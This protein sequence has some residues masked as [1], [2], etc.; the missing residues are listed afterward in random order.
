MNKQFGDKASPSAGP[1][2]QTHAKQQAAVRKRIWLVQVSLFFSLW[3]CYGLLINSRNLEA[4]NLQQAG[5]EAMV[6][7]GQF[8][9]D[10]SSAPQLQMRAYYDKGKPFGDVFLYN[11]KQ[12][13]NKQPGQF[14][15]GA[16]V[17]LF[18]H[19][20]GLNYVNN[21]LLTSA[22]VTFFTASLFAAVT[23]AAVFGIV[24]EFT[25]RDSL[26][27]PMA[28]ALIYGL[29]TTALV[30][31]GVALHDPLASGFLIIAFYIVLLLGRLQMPKRPAKTAAAAAGVCLGLTVTT[32]LLPL[33]MSFVVGVYLVSLRRR[34]LIL[35]ALIGSLVGLAPLL[36]YDAV[37]FG[38]PFVPPYVVAGYSEIKM[39]F[40]LPTTVSKIRFYLWQITFYVPILWVGLWGLAFY[41][42]PLQRERLVFVGLLI[43]LLIQILN[44]D[45]QGGC[46]YGPRFLLPLIPFACVGLGGVF[47]LRAKAI[48]LLATSAMTLAAAFSIFVSFVGS[49]FGAMYCETEVYALGPYLRAVSDPGWKDMPLVAW[50]LLPFAVSVSLLIYFLRIFQRAADVKR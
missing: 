12:Y 20:F 28:C 5:V 26:F 13:A 17:Y 45:A 6:E 16:V 8:N 43:A 10:G 35:P 19:F 50:L 27:W 11:G 32:S 29:G 18:L 48:K 39:R 30:Y 1:V 47:Y 49:I 24:R 15:A 37:C 7:R 25:G 2:V 38:N 44:M 41:P 42:R 36:F 4:F 34:D 21:Y 40:D 14:M 23:G 3:F 9:L 22:L 31:S 46:Q 33:L